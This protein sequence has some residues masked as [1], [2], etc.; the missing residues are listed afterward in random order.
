MGWRGQLAG[1]KKPESIITMKNRWTKDEL[2]DL[3]ENL[4][5]QLVELEFKSLKKKHAKIGVS[6]LLK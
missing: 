1:R 2:I 5:K 4:I 6:D 3:C